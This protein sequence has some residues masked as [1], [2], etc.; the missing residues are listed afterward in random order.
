MVLACTVTLHHIPT[1]ESHGTMDSSILLH[2]VKELSMKIYPSEGYHTINNTCECNE[3]TIEL[4]WYHALLFHISVK[5]SLITGYS[6]VSSTAYSGYQRR[7]AILL[8]SCEGN[9]CNGKC[10]SV[11]CR[12]NL[13]YWSWLN[14]IIWCHASLSSLFQV[15][16]CR[17]CHHVIIWINAE[18]QYD[19][20][21]SG[22]FCMERC[23]G[24]VY[25]T[26]LSIIV[27]THDWSIYYTIISIVYACV[28]VCIYAILSWGIHIDGALRCNCTIN[29]L[30]TKNA[31][32]PTHTLQYMLWLAAM[33]VCKSTIGMP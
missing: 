16:G 25:I 27:D 18:L 28:R 20:N 21:F 30:S 19:K 5:E 23:Q 2:H 32:H 31:F 29:H 11:S 1:A 6:M 17:I 26:R 10:G 33:F 12:H 3:T 22:R 24:S 13:Y 7:H 15:M 8:S 9:P 4:E 14:D